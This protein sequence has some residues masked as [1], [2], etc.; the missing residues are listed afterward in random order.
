MIEDQQ[1]ALAQTVERERKPA[2]AITFI[3]VYARLI[4]D[5][6]G[7]KSLDGTGQHLRQ[8]IQI[9]FISCPIIEPYVDG[10]LLLYERVI[11]LTVER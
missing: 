1:I 10:A 11:L 7:P 3:R 6:V 2:Q 4:K 5:Y 8:R 9:L